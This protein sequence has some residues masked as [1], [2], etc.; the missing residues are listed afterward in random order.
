MSQSSET[1]EVRNGHSQEDLKETLQQNVM[2][3]PGWDPGTD[4]NHYVKSKEI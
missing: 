4:E 3:Y 1:M 2:W